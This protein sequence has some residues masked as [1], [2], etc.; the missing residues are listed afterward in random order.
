MKLT[1]FCG[2]STGADMGREESLSDQA[3]QIP[4]FDLAS[5]SVGEEQEAACAQWARRGGAAWG[6]WRVAGD[7]LR[8]A[9]CLMSSAPER[10][11]SQRSLRCQQSRDLWTAGEDWTSNTSRMTPGPMQGANCISPSTLAIDNSTIDS[12][13]GKVTESRL[14]TSSF[15][16]TLKQT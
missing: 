10:A 4:H 16:N 14:P 12:K 13:S 5:K 11:D 2:S 6:G 3:G 9:W 7:L 15:P 8:G 1:A